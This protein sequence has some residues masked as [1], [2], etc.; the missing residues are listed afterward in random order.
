LLMLKRNAPPAPAFETQNTTNVNN[1][2]NDIVLTMPFYQCL[3]GCYEAL[4]EHFFSMGSF[5]Y[6]EFYFLF[7]YISIS[8]MKKTIKIELC[9]IYTKNSI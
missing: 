3:L 7:Y 8:L 2:K 5:K 9:G 4:I 1:N 6:Y